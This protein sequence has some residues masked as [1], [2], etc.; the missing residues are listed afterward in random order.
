MFEIQEET[1]HS[2][3]PLVLRL[4]VL[5]LWFGAAQSTDF[6]LWLPFENT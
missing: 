4:P 3:R 6:G 5:L 1:D 2:S